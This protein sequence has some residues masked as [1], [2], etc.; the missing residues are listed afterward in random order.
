[1]AIDRNEIVRHGF[2]SASDKELIR[3]AAKRLV[4]QDVFSQLTEA[5]LEDGIAEGIEFLLR[6]PLPGELP[7][8]LP[9]DQVLDA[10][11]SELRARIARRFGENG[12]IRG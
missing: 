8:D 5:P 10:V 3:F 1:M 12:A 7:E 11:Q 6:Q 2:E 4:E 9:G